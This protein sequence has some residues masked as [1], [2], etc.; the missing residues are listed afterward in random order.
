MGY[1]SWKAADWWRQPKEKKGVAVNNTE[2][3]WR[4]EECQIQDM[5]IQN[6]GVCPALFLY[7]LTMF[8]FVPFGTVMHTLCHGT[9]EI[10]DLFSAFDLWR[11]LLLRDCMCLRRE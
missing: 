5:E 1:L 8:P 7:I 2:R 10:R 4:T 6:L 3:S 9:L 11:G